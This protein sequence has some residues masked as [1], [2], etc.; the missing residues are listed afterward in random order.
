MCV[1]QNT[2]TDNNI[3]F[4][5]KLTL[6]VFQWVNTV[7]LVEHEM[8]HLPFEAEIQDYVKFGSVNFITIAVNNTLTPNTLPT[9]E[10]QYK[11]GK[12]V[13]LI[14]YYYIYQHIFWNQ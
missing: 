11:T 13:H 5:I 8:G 10:I 9:G 1:V 2:T 6:S 14:H 7:Y 12:Y 3:R 4:S